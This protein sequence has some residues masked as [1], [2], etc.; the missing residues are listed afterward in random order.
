MS[1]VYQILVYTITIKTPLQDGIDRI[2]SEIR[3]LKEIF[4]FS[5]YEMLHL[6]AEA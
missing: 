4:A 5:K 2:C 6:C 3:W 1:G